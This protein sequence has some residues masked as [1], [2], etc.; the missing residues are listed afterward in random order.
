MP[1]KRPSPTETQ[2][3]WTEVIAKAL[4]Y[5]A[6][7]SE[8]SRLRKSLNAARFFSGSAFHTRTQRNCSAAPKPHSESC[9]GSRTSPRARGRPA[10]SP[11]RWRQT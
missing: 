9:C 2:P 6:V 10:A 1:S 3:D 7:N 5:L 8:H 11:A 4:A